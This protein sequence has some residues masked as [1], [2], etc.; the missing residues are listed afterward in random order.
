MAI[1]ILPN[2]WRA[3][4]LWL[5][6]STSTCVHFPSVHTHI[7]HL[8]AI[9][10]GERRRN[11][12]KGHASM[13]TSLTLLSKSAES[14][15]SPSGHLDPSSL[16]LAS[17]NTVYCQSTKWEK[18]KIFFKDCNNLQGKRIWKGAYTYTHMH[19]HTHTHTHT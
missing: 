18:W 9:F 5:N 2:S 3:C 6:I 4:C 13:N 11:E 19:T 12:G 1:C 10:Q 7:P 16:I 8:Q 15:Q 14:P 17:F